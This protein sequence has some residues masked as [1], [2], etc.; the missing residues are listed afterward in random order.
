[1]GEVYRGRDERLR[2]DVAIKVL[3]ARLHGDPAHVERLSREA[4]AAGGLNHPNILAVYDVGTETGVPYVV[5]ELLQ[6]QS[7]RER[8]SGGPLPYPKALQYGIQIAHALG[9]AHEKKI[10]HRDVK[11]AN[12]FI[13]SDGRIKLLDFGLA[14]RSGADG[15]ADPDDSTASGE[16]ERNWGTAGYMP[17]EQLLGQPV[18]HRAD[19]F[20]LGAVL[21]EMFTGVRAFQRPTDS[22]VRNAVLHAEPVDARELNPRLPEGAVAVL[23]RCL[24][25]NKEE[26]YQSA[27]DLG[28][29][30]QQLLRDVESSRSSTLPGPYPVPRRVAWMRVLLATLA[31]VAT[32]VAGVLVSRALS[33]RPAPSFEQ[34][35]F[36]RGRIG[37]A[38]FASEGR[39]VVYSEA[40]IVYSEG[41][42]KHTLEVWRLDLSDSPHS[43]RLGYEGAD[44]LAARRG[45]LA[46]S[47]QRRYG[48]GRRF[49]GTLATAPAG[50][51]GMPRELATN[52]E[53]A[54]WDPAGV[55]LAV[56]RWT[57]GGGESALEYPL[58][59]QLYATGDAVRTPRVSRDGR[60]IAFID[61][62]GGGGGGRIAIVDLA[63]N[64]S[65]LTDQWF[66]ARGLAWSPDG[67][68]IW[69]AAAQGR[70]N[71]ALRAVT[72]DK[73]QRVLLE[74]PGS[75]TLWDVDPE[76]HVLLS[77]DEERSAVVGMAPGW[78][79]ERD[80]SWFDASGVAD[81]SDDGR[82]LL[83]G[84][85]FGVY[86]R[87]TDGSPA[88]HLG[89]KDGFADDLSPDG[90]MALA[91]TP[92]TGQLMI[93]PTR[94]G[95]PRPLPT[96][97][98]TSYKGALWSPDGRHI[99]FN[100][101]AHDTDLRSYVQ[102][103]EPGST[104]PPRPL[105]PKDVW[106]TAISPDA[107]WTAATEPGK[108]MSL[109]SVDGGSR[110]NVPN[111]E[112]EDRP[113]AFSEDGQW[114]WVFQR[115]KVPAEVL[116]VNIETG[117]RV[118]WKTLWPADP[119]GVYSITRFKVTPA[120]HA[121]FYSYAGALSQLYLVR[122]L[123]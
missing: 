46:L 7:L 49:V 22:E 76:G 89:L 107:R 35:T 103:V 55:N 13:T 47:L 38:R 23:R 31:A 41:A 98:M 28:F 79:A 56:A 74:V 50:G 20:A 25:K 39:A 9:A 96:H 73:R 4:R 36:R 65:Y 15:R 122:G 66:S 78:T 30:L 108:G 10:W 48:G 2:R 64:V 105:T 37:G 92:S 60:R 63:R 24:E 32:V 104:M 16:P 88:K 18:D 19:L 91:T 8:L 12:V 117:R 45:D 86:T 51:E 69:F 5:S 110:R 101:L 67:R 112:P 81:L 3:N 102:D 114:L 58:G 116:R 83:F 113:V 62:R 61:D 95:E 44:V 119:A 52:V 34:L 120:G 82:M 26:R 40:R 17:P 59:Q 53:E 109:W 121:Y 68:E 75:L 1:M 87:G 100:G 94:A 33:G 14:T 85:R 90:S 29:H 123:K 21:Y 111:S 54:D 80:L 115:G 97:G 72:L 43:R 6:G 99:I 42:P 84:D 70:D 77:R 93:L 71:R 11:P 27:R 118:P 57:G 106:V